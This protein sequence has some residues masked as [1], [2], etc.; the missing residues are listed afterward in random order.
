MPA[1]MTISTIIIFC[2]MVVGHAIKSLFCLVSLA[3]VMC[4]CVFHCNEETRLIPKYIYGLCWLSMG[5]S[6]CLKFIFASCKCA[7]K[8]C[9]L[10]FDLLEH[11]VVAHLEMPKSIPAHS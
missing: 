8:A 5:I 9:G 4:A 10:S 11:S 6:W 3:V 2:F 7:L 1:L